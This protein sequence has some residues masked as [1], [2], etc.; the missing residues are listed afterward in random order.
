V[1]STFDRFWIEGLSRSKLRKRED[2]EAITERLREIKA[3]DCS[4][5]RKIEMFKLEV[6]L[7]GASE[8]QRVEAA[9]L[10]AEEE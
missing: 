10:A 1:G 4:V 5:A 8:E 7:M 6:S 3:K 9:R 2:V